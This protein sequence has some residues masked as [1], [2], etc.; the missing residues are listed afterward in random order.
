M[1]SNLV[2]VFWQLVVLCKNTAV[3]F[4]MLIMFLRFLLFAEINQQSYRPANALS[5]TLELPHSASAVGSVRKRGQDMDFSN[6]GGMNHQHAA[7]IVTITQLDCRLLMLVHILLC[8][9]WLHGSTSMLYT[10]I[11]CCS[12]ARSRGGSSSFS[13]WTD[14]TAKYGHKTPA[15]YSISNARIGKSPLLLTATKAKNPDV[16]FCVLD[17]WLCPYPKPSRRLDSNVNQIYQ[18]SESEDQT[19]VISGM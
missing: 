14:R 10:V 9:G 3:S 12:A 16:R 5:Q 8:P 11:L 1:S 4:L 7:I 6:E 17:M 19:S 15:A 2:F 13:I 18:S